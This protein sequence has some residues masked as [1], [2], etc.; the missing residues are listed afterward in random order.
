M[1][2]KSIKK[3]KKVARGYAAQFGTGKK[4]GEGTTYTFLGQ[5]DVWTEKKKKDELLVDTQEYKLVQQR[6]DAYCNDVSMVVV[7]LDS[8]STYIQSKNK[9]PYHFNQL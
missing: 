4:R 6:M 3:K 2:W 1:E 9:K 8:S 7:N 5:N